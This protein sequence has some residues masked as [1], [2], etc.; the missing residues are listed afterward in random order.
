MLTKPLA[1][2]AGIV[3]AACAAAQAQQDIEPP[4]TPPRYSFDRVG[5]SLLRLDTVNGQLTVCSQRTA[6][7]W[8][9]QAV[10]EDR[11][12]LEQEIERLQDDVTSLKAEIAALRT[13][14]PPP[15]PPVELTPPAGKESQSGESTLKMPTQEDIDRAR[16]AVEKAWHRLVDMIVNLKNDVMRK[17]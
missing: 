9:C 7:G 12:A 17:G 10:P 3:L 4:K 8:V 2:A 13:P 14:P 1:I 15:R 5:D 6:V 16:V 11:A